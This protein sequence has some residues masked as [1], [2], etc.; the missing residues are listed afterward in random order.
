MTSPVIQSLIEKDY[1]VLLMDEPIDEYV[2]SRI[3]HFDGKKLVNI[4]KGEF[5]LP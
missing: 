3:T 5:K 1:E 2:L 4:A